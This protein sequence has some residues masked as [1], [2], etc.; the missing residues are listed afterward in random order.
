MSRFRLLSDAQWA[1]IEDLLPAR[2]GKRGRPFRDAR[3]VVGGIIYRDRCGIAWR[4]VPEVFG[5]WL[6]ASGSHRRHASPTTHPSRSRPRRQGLF[7]LGYPRPAAPT[8]RFL[9]LVRTVIGC[10]ALD[11]NCNCKVRVEISWGERPSFG[12]RVRRSRRV[13]SPQ[14]SPYASKSRRQEKLCAVSQDACTRRAYTSGWCTTHYRRLRS[15]QDMDAP[16][17]R[18]VRY[19]E[20][21]D[22]KPNP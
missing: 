22:D 13:G 1:L 12:R 8:R 21:A 3:Q 11:V 19:D 2:T 16:I 4:D 20:G 17:R 18:Y 10:T 6:G 14:A 15:G 9:P 7:E 5:P